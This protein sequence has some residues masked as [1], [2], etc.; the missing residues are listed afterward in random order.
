MFLLLPGPSLTL[1]CPRCF[2]DGLHIKD[3]LWQGIHLLAEGLCDACGF[4]FYQ[5]LPVGH[6]LDFPVAFG[7]EEPVYFVS[8]QTGAWHYQPLVKGYYAPKSNPVPLTRKVF[9]KAKKVIVLNCLDK[10]YG[11]AV[12]RLFN[13]QFHLEQDTELGLVVLLP[14]S[15]EWLVPDGVAEVWLVE[16]QLAGLEGWLS[17]LDA[18]VKQWLK[19]YEEVYVSHAYSHPDMN[20]VD[21]ALFTRIPKFDLQQFNQLPLQVTFVWREDRFW[22]GHYW[23]HLLWLL[24]KKWAFP[25]L[26]QVYFVFR[27]KQHI[28]STAHKIKK[29]FPQALFCVTGFGKTGRFPDWFQDLRT[30][31]LNSYSQQQWNLVYANSQLVIG[32]LGSDMLFPTALAAGFID[33][34][35]PYRLANFMEDVA[36]RVLNRKNFFLGRSLEVFASPKLVASHA[37]E[38][39]KGYESF[40]ENVDRP[41]TQLPQ[42]AQLAKLGYLKRMQQWVAAKWKS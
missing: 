9:Y 7:K 17:G 23:E 37:V 34:I 32:I 35:P 24:T 12:F 15:L 28:L 40:A 21:I 5:T 22:L 26:N 27:Q 29:A 31:E 16:G 36:T 19:M 25:Y 38:M 6:D 39:L 33:L 4:A 42:A 20:Q 1:T 30:Q 18:S 13:A 10:V 3:T 8:P 2:K 14:A 41:Y 11:H